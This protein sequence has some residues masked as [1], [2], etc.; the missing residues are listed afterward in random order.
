MGRVVEQFV[1]AHY[2]SAERSLHEQMKHTM[3]VIR[4]APKEKQT[5]TIWKTIKVA[6]PFF[7]FHCIC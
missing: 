6:L 3:E 5:N 7:S 1:S 4:Q 2:I